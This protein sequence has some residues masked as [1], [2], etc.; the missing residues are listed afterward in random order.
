MSDDTISTASIGTRPRARSGHRAAIAGPALGEVA[1]RTFDMFVA[2][3]ALL[4]MSPLLG[5]IAVLVRLDSPGEIIYRGA[6]V[7]RHGRP[8]KLCKFRTMVGDADRRGPLVT[9][10]DDA[11]VTRVGRALRRTKLD[12]LP[13][14][15]N[16]LVGDMSLVGPRPENPK[17][18]ALYNE[19][20]RGVWSVRPG[21]TSP[22][23]IKYRNE[24][25][26]L[27]GAGSNLDERY[28]AIMQDKLELE[29]DYLRN[30]S[31]LR[32][33]LVLA[34]TIKVIFL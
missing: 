2:G 34:R 1:K 33:L 11:R 31:L 10:G 18:A 3:C 20:Q 17:S 14:F 32:D 5:A 16:V 25:A 4:V 23:T 28:L 19:R 29:L 15:W 30:R 7:G 24:E 13:S 27:A 6:R 8:F 26:L 12:E 21:L 9:A 22:A